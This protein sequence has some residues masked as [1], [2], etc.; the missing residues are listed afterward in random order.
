MKMNKTILIILMLC[1]VTATV[2]VY[3]E[4]EAPHNCR[5][6]ASISNNFP[7]GIIIQQ[8]IND[9]SSLQK[10]G[11]SNRDGWGIASYNTFLS[12]ANISRG[13]LSA[14]TDIN[15]D[16][17]ATNLESIKPKIVLGHVRICVTGCCAHDGTIPNP[18]PFIRY[19]KNG[20]MWAF[21]HNGVVSK[22]TM[23]TLIKPEYLI[24]NPYNGGFIPE[25]NVSNP[26]LIVDSE[27]YMAFVMQ[28]IEYNDWNVVKGIVNATKTMVSAGLGSMN[29]VFSDG[30]KVWGFRLG[31]SLSYLN[32]GTYY[33]V[34]SQPTSSSDKWTTM[35]DYQLVEL[36][37]DSAPKVIDVRT[38]T[39]PVEQCTENWQCTEY[40]SCLGYLQLRDCNDLNK[41]NTTINK[42]IEAKLC[43]MPCIPNWQCGAWGTCS[44]EGQ[45]LR[46]C[47]DLNNCKPIE[48]QS[49][50]PECIIQWTCNQWSVC[51]N[52]NQQRTCTNNC[53]SETRIEN[54]YCT[55]PGIELLSNPS[56][57]TNTVGW[58]FYSTISA[59]GARITSDYDSSPAAYKITV[60]N[61]GT[62]HSNIQFFTKGISIENGKQYRL[63]MRVKS[64]VPVTNL[65]GVNLINPS[66]PYNSYAVEATRYYSSGTAWSTLD[67][68]FTAKIT[69][70]NARI[71]IY[72]GKMP[73]SSYLLIDTLSFK[74]VN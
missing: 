31:N 30:E 74:E 14:N 69:T 28:Q 65:I 55:M 20:K 1:L 23:A 29:F 5:M 11:A 9:S 51:D 44:S 62:S 32:N 70:S 73:S 71:T 43:D 26:N 68:I 3:A 57:T 37:S 18:H 10:L 47:I 17:T 27:M 50:I 58:N 7:D 4:E 25:C 33:S 22:T 13:K 49:C 66:S 59:T 63:T 12:D 36:S 45:Q 46:E 2:V 53:D 64:S 21:A 56:F 41:C 40:G 72:N 60:V 52:N 24:D 48:Q 34:A 15:F 42:P 67:I 19:E 35:N 6:M 61:Q 38:W 8:L 54:Q 39:E 16:I